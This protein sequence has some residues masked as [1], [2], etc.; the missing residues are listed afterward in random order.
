MEGVLIVIAT[1]AVCMNAYPIRNNG[2][3]FESL[4]S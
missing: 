1:I 4:H 2:T 3:Y